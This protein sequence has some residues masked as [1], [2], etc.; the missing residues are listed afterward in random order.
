MKAKLKGKN[1]CIHEWCEKHYS[2]YLNL[3]KRG[4]S[5]ASTD[6]LIRRYYK[7]YGLVLDEDFVI[8]MLKS[9]PEN[10][11][12]QLPNGHWEFSIVCIWMY[13]KTKPTLR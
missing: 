13:A 5:C 9:L 7:N 12:K 4:C 11:A 10:C 6:F 1:D 8:G 3:L 2:F